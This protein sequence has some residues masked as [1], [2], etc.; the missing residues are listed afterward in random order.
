[1]LEYVPVATGIPVVLDQHNI[2]EEYWS[3]RIRASSGLAKLLAVINLRR[4]RAFEAAQAPRLAAYV[5]VSE[6]DAKAVAAKFGHGV[7]NVIVA[8]NGVE[9]IS[10]E[11]SSAEGV[12]DHPLRLAFMGSLD[13]SFNRSAA[14]RLCRT[15]APLVWAWDPTVEIRI[16]GRKPSQYL[17][18]LARQD[19]RVVV[20]GE[21]VDVRG[22]L[23]SSDVFVA[24]LRDGAGT[25]LKVVEALAARLPVVGSAFAFEGLGGVDGED[26]V[27]AESDEEVAC[28]VRMLA[29]D[30]KAMR[31]LG[32]NGAHLVERRFLWGAI[33]GR[34]FESLVVAGA[35]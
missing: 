8:E 31:R 4:V 11:R 28:K 24:P 20:T 1:M 33:C 29:A 14:E 17:C 13:L 10:P 21:V 5:S 27:T 34:L 19:Q 9:Q 7:R 32:E 12:Y 35:L 6:R 2:D 16:I 25:K 3:R 15:I 18:R 30:R 26:F 23:V 22:W